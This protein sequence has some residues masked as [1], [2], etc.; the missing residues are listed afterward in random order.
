MQHRG[1]PL[2]AGILFR[3]VEQPALQRKP[4]GGRDGVIPGPREAACAYARISAG[5]ALL[6]KGNVAHPYGHRQY[7]DAQR[8][9][10]HSRLQGGIVDGA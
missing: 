10:I 5:I 3:Q 4:L 6:G 1:C 8:R 2:V 7:A 9:I